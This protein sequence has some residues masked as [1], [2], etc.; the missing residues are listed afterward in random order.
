MYRLIIRWIPQE[1][2]TG[3]ETLATLNNTDTE[4]IAKEILDHYV[5]SHK[6]EIDAAAK[7]IRRQRNQLKKLTNPIGGTE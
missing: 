6:A 5:T 1:I 2:L 7:V 3:L 4:E